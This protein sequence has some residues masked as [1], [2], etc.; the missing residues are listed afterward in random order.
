MM[1]AGQ[2]KKSPLKN[3]D[4]IAML[5]IS[6]RNAM[7]KSYA[8][9]QTRDGQEHAWPLGKCVNALQAP[10]RLLTAGSTPPP[11]SSTEVTNRLQ[12]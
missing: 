10:T 12:Q 7:Q 9:E 3:D 6:S 4:E 1:H 2:E 8:E 5:C 11:Q